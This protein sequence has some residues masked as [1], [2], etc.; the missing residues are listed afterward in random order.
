MIKFPMLY[1]TLKR[2]GVQ[3]VLRP[4]WQPIIAGS[5]FWSSTVIVPMPLMTVPFNRE[6]FQRPNYDDS[7]DSIS[8]AR[9][10]AELTT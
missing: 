5:E 4:C 1:T 9:H 6:R 8:A 3:V 7:G 10:S 2:L